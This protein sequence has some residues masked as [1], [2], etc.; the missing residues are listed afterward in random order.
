MRKAKY[1]YQ[2]KKRTVSDKRKKVLKRIMKRKSDPFKNN[3]EKIRCF[4]SIDFPIELKKEIKRIQ[5]LL[6]KKTLLSGRYIEPENL[7][8]TLKFL[9]FVDKRK[10]A[11][12]EKRLK[13]VSFE[14][15]TCY[16]SEVG[17]F[18]QQK[19][20]KKEIRI[21]WVKLDGKGIFELQEK[22]DEALNGLFRPEHRFMSHVTIARVK[23]V[24]DSEKLLEYLDNVK[25][26]KFKFIVKDFKLMKSELFKD[27]PE[28]SEISN[29]SAIKKK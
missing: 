16:P 20:R 27:G 18:Y 24:H 9:G 3:D 22:V 11:E 21:I 19:K 10:F 28:Y 1:F 4:I 14:E 5:G 12:A 29:Y 26:E 7:H 8:L 13:E 2:A 6:Q 25:P 15:F 23:H 17:V